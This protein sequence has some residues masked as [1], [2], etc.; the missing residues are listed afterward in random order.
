[1]PKSS[2][3]T[4]WITMSSPPP[5]TPTG[6]GRWKTCGP[7]WRTWRRPTAKRSWSWRPPTPSPPRTRISAPT[8]SA[9]AAS[10]RKT[11]P[12]PCRA[13]PTPC[14]TWSRPWPI[15][16]TASASAT[17]R[18]PGSAWAAPPGR[19]TPRSGRSTAQAGPPATPPP[20]TRTTRANTTAAAPWTIRPSST[21][22][23]IPW[24]R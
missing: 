21:R 7:C 13:R 3:T 11:I 19:K 24:R 9:R 2:P 16:R 15:P 20:T 6:T 18:A 5:I 4:T 8:P 1:M 22:R 10:S 17:G 14:A 12:T 23:G